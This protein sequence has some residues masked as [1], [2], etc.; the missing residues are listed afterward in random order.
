MRSSCT[1]RGARR[2]RGARCPEPSTWSGTPESIRAGSRPARRGPRARGP[3]RG[4]RR[5]RRVAMTTALADSSNGSCT[6]AASWARRARRRPAT[7]TS[8]RTPVTRP[9]VVTRPVTRCRNRT[10]TRPVAAGVEQRADE[11]LEDARAG[12]PRDVEPRHRVAVPVGQVAAALGP[13]HQREP[14]HALGVQPRAAGRPAANSTNPS[15]HARPQRSEPSVGEVGGPEPVGERQ[16]GGVLARRGGAARGSR[17]GTARR[18][19]RTP[20]RPGSRRARRRAG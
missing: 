5:C 13:L 14:A 18:T 7:S 6:V 17:R 10:S 20:A 3:G 8:P 2:L 15:A 9:S 11:R 19:T 1:T 16:L 4:W 12:A